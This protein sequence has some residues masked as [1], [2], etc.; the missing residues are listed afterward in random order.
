[1]CHGNQG[2]L[3]STYSFCF[4]VSILGIVGGNNKDEG[5]GEQG[6]HGQRERLL[7]P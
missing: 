4:Y 2:Y 1:M 3:R 5:P 7:R 6:V